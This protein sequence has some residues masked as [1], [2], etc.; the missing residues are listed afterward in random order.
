MMKPFGK[1]ITNLFLEIDKLLDYN[2]KHYQ[3]INEYI[4]NKVKYY[5]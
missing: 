5:Y 1:K 2:I 3:L 4:I